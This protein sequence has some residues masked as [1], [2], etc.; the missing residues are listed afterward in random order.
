MSDSVAFISD[1]AEAWATEF[2]KWQDAA[3]D[4]H[5]L[6][7]E[8]GGNQ[9][10]V[11]G[12][13]RRVEHV[14]ASELT[15][16]SCIHWVLKAAGLA[17][18]ET[19]GSSEK[20]AQAAKSA[21]SSAYLPLCISSGK[22]QILCRTKD[23]ATE[24]LN[25]VTR[26]ALEE[27]PGLDLSGS[28]LK[29][30]WKNPLVRAM[31]DLGQKQARAKNQGSAGVGR[32][33]RLPLT[34]ECPSSGQRAGVWGAFGKE[35]ADGISKA[36][37]EKRRAAGD[38]HSRLKKAIE[39]NSADGQGALGYLEALT[40]GTKEASLRMRA[41]LLRSLDYYFKDKN[42]DE[43]QRW[44]GVVHADGNGFGMMFQSVFGKDG[45]YKESSKNAKY[46]QQYRAFS[47]EL[48]EA[49]QKSV[50]QAIVATHNKKLL[51]QQYGSTVPFTMESDPQLNSETHGEWKDDD[52]PKG[53]EYTGLQILPLIIGG[54]DVTV[55]VEGQWALEWTTQFLK[56]FAKSSEDFPTLSTVLEQANNMKLTG[57][58][59]VALVKHH[60]PFFTAYELAEEL[61]GKAKNMHR[62]KAGDGKV[63]G[64]T[65]I[66]FHVVYDSSSPK[67]DE[68]RA[69]ME[70]PLGEEPAVQPGSEEDKT[71]KTGGLLTCRPLRLDEKADNARSWSRFEKRV[72]AISKR[73]EEG[74]YLLPL[75]QVQTI[76]EAVHQSVSAGDQVYALAK[77]GMSHRAKTALEAVMEESSPWTQDPWSKRQLTGV[78][79][80]LDGLEF[81]SDAVNAGDDDQQPLVE[82]EE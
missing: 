77:A 42:P 48:D 41:L 68:A 20:L 66:D 9:A 64:G 59:G 29:V 19:L 56:A 34:A 44:I 3:P 46:I 11:F 32:M 18:K 10:Y 55:L 35:P 81:H 47:R 69:V 72:Q 28:I 39:D 2:K 63:L 43:D 12:S 52:K 7:L 79:D 62:F 78:I 82:G 16:R 57:C 38:A 40:Q 61:A 27:A 65:W 80:A 17:D 76:R 15:Y 53:K 67:L 60:F 22:A 13:R 45:Q 54:D 74:K 71:E 5:A 75:S 14:G 6:H 1:D 25:K 50:A 31:S 4:C 21:Y 24:L 30:D 51:S 37:W 73:S 36:S 23:L 58:A 26:K 70:V 33:L 8:T 49:V